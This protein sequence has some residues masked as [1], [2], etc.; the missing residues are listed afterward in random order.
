MKGFA[1]LITLAIISF[2]YIG[3]DGYEHYIKR[4][5]HA[6]Y[7]MAQSAKTIPAKLQV[8]KKALQE[9]QAKHNQEATSTPIGKK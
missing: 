7:V 5:G 1:A 4:F 6:V 9:Y 8:L 2:I 3:Q